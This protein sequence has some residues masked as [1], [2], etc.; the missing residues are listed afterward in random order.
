MVIEV[1]Q[2]LMPRSVETCSVVEFGK[3]AR[4]KANYY[5]G[6]KDILKKTEEKDLG[7]TISI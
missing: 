6:N 4:T 5:F 7:A 1:E 2:S 3:S